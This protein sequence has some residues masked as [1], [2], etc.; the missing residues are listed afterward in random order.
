LL[1]DFPSDV[2]DE[3]LYYVKLIVDEL[4]DYLD[5]NIGHCYA[6]EGSA[7]SGALS[8]LGLN[9]VQSNLQSSS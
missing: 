4:L 5:G 6:A 7:L 8:N 9:S 3:I 1:I 2:V